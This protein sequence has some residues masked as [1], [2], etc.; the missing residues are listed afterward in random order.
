MSAAIGLDRRFANFRAGLAARQAALALSPAPARRPSSIGAERLA[1]TLDGELVRTSRG[2]FVRIEAPTTLLPLDRTRLA[3]L[4]G[5]PPA[6]A[7]LLC[8]DTE[9]TGLATAAGTLA[10]LVG[11]GWWEG[12]E[13]R[14]LQLLMPDQSDELA[15]LAELASIIPA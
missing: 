1:A 5:Q 14:Q 7:P 9:T 4:P 12:D 8:L 2:S 3:T 10:F 15:L 6:E 11:L 13:F